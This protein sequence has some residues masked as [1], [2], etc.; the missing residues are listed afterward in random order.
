M[1]LYSSACV[2]MRNSYFLLPVGFLVIFLRA[3]V[4]F[5]SGGRGGEQSPADQLFLR[6]P[7]II[8]IL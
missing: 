1:Q 2:C 5:G 4:C 3:A 8:A 6:N 7:P